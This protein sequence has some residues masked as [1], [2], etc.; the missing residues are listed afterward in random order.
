MH[1]SRNRLL[2]IVCLPLLA[3]AAP[4]IPSGVEGVA[5]SQAIAVAKTAL[6]PEM[7][8]ADGTWSQSS[9][10]IGKKALLMRVQSGQFCGDVGCPTAVLVQT[11]GGWSTA[12]TG[13]SAGKAR[14]LASTHHG[15]HDIAIA[16][17]GGYLALRFDGHSFVEAP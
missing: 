7:Y 4:G 9:L 3:A 16:A 2:A 8:G 1:L 6:A 12:W 17:R 14:V 15:L 10:A 5:Q 13:M 11:T